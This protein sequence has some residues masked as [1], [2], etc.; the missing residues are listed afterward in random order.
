M[1]FDGGSVWGMVFVLCFTGVSLSEVDFG[2]GFML[3]YLLGY[4]RGA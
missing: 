2:E 4:T 1:L 3:S